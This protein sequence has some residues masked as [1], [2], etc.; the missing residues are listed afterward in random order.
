M[1]QLASIGLTLHLPE[2]WSLCKAC[3]PLLHI[4]VLREIRKATL[5][6]AGKREIYIPYRL[7]A[8]PSPHDGNVDA[9]QALEQTISPWLHWLYQRIQ[10]GAGVNPRQLYT[11]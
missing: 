6:I 10:T 1:T 5:H 9:H 11:S 2:Y 7:T 4:S 3:H 8:M